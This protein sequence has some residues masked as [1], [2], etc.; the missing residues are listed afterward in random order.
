MTSVGNRSFATFDNL[1]PTCR[2]SM[3]PEIEINIMNTYYKNRVRN[4]VGVAVVATTLVGA[5]RSLQASGVDNERKLP[6]GMNAADWRGIEAAHEIARHSIV[7]TA[8]GGFAAR[9]AG[10][11][12]RTEFDGKGFVTTPRDRSWTWG[13]ELRAI[14]DGLVA[15]AERGTAE[16]NRLAFPRS[17]EV[18]EWFVNRSGGLQQ[19][20]TILK[21]PALEGDGIRL[22]LGVRGDLRAKVRPTAVEFVDATQGVVLTYGGLLAWDGEG[23][24]LPVEFAALEDGIAIRVDDRDAVYP[25]TIDP[26]AQQA[27]VKASNTD[28]N[29]AFG[30]SVAMSGDTA[31]VGAPEEDSTANAVNGNQ[32]NNAGNNQGAAYVF[33]RENGVWSQQAYLKAANSDAL[34]YFG[35]SVGISGDLIIVGAPRENSGTDGLNSLPNETAADAGAAYLF[36]RSGSSWSQTL[37]VKASNPGAGDRFGESVAISGGTFIVG[38]PNEDSGS[39]TIDGVDGDGTE[40]AGAAYV[41]AFNGFTYVQQ[42]YL[43]ASNTSANDEFGTS[44]AVSADLLPGEPAY[45]VVG[46]PFED[47][48]VN[49][50]GAAYGYIRVGGNWSLVNLM[51][52]ANAGAD[53][54]FGHSVAMSGTTIVVGAPEEDSPGSGVN[55]GTGNG[56]NN[57][58]AAYVFELPGFFWEQTAYLKA[59]LNDDGVGNNFGR[60]VSISD[61]LIVVGAPFEDSDSVGVNGSQDNLGAN[62]SGAAFVYRRSGSSWI[63]QSYLKASNTSPGDQFGGAV[64]VSGETAIVGAL[65]ED[66]GATGI[67]GSQGV[68]ATASGASY[69]FSLTPAVTIPGA[70]VDVVGPTLR[71]RGRKSIETLRKRVVFRGTAKDASGV[72]RIIVKASGAKVRKTRLRGNGTWKSVLKVRK[73]RGRVIVRIRAIDNVGNSSAQ[74]KV[75]ILRR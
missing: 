17:E 68:G 69:I 7:K 54:E 39:T 42:A 40:Q 63:S 23:R 58:G 52:A 41:F 51:K 3:L 29:D 67:G 24:T 72:S 74:S 32:A 11:D 37:Y 6:A 45:A 27:Y 61:N 25:I 1:A 35:S 56:A 62:N 10:Q 48:T 43:K 20:W 21:R 70:S 18:F 59:I 38:A 75:R 53:D 2:S 28:A 19:G 12:W 16:E 22:E 14:G 60:S 33:V 46:A 15:P 49:D 5:G 4:W 9:S 13:L 65:D 30:I 8:D 26:V 31:V 44:V 34:D 36:T 47:T 66:S 57:A 55:G 71:V 73:E 64:A 50:S